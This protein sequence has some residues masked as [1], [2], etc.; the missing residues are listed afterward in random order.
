MKIKIGLLILFFF[1]VSPKL[2]VGNVVTVCGVSEGFSYYLPG[3]AVPKDQAGWQK[4]QLSQGKIIFQINNGN[5]DILIYDAKGYMRSVKEEGG[6]VEVPYFTLTNDNYIVT[7]NYRQKGVFEHFLF[8]L[9]SLGN[10]QVVW[11]SDR[12]EGLIRKSSLFQATCKK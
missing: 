4:D 10:G 5:P 9:D 12:A 1:T 2:A 7:V 6:K 8:N 3:G 11:G